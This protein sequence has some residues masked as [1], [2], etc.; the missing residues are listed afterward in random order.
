MFYV[1]LYLIILDLNFLF[2]FKNSSVLLLLLFVFELLE[3]RFLWFLRNF[4]IN[5]SAICLFVFSFSFYKRPNSRMSIYEKGFFF[6]S[7]KIFPA[8]NK[9]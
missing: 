7:L 2:F 3:V 9:H 5:F 6:F 4:R 8:N 1:T